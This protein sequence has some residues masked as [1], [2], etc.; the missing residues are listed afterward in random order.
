MFEIRYNFFP[1]QKKQEFMYNISSRLVV[2][3][4]NGSS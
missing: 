2:R 3:M 4:V 1:Y